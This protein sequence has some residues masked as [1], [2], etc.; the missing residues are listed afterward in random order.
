MIS[1]TANPLIK[2]VVALHTPKGR[3]AKG[4]C[5]AE[6]TRTIS[7]LIQAGWMPEYIFATKILEQTAADQSEGHAITLVSDAVMKKLSAASTPSGILAVFPIPHEPDPRMLTSG[8][9]L[10]EISDPGNMGTLIRTCA[11]FDKHSIVIIDGCDPYS[12]KVIQSCA[13]TIAQV[14][15]FRWTWQELLTH[16]KT[17]PLV[18]LVAQ[19]GQIPYALNAPDSLIVIGSEAHG[20]PTEWASSCEF[21]VTIP[22]P[23]GTESL[24]AAVAGGIA[25]YAI[26]FRQK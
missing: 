22:M 9:V 8:A 4:R 11:A 18:C 16:K 10:A 13:G 12:P 1:S 6:G 5:I 19:G 17:I 3:K 23:G 25:F 2:Q 26:W 20:I 15:V 14:T 24:N 7:T 21:R